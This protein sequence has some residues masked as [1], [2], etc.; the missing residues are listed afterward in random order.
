ML[1]T[2]AEHGL[3]PD[4]LLRWGIRQRLSQT[5]REEMSRPPAERNAFLT[6]MREGPIAIATDKANEQHYELPPAYFHTAL[7]PALKYSSCH[8]PEGC[9]HLNE[10]E[11]ATLELTV[12]RAGIRD[13]MSILELGCGWGSLSLFMARKFPHSR[14]VA[15][16]NSNPQR[17]FIQGRAKVEGLSHLEIRTCDMNR[18]EPG[19]TFDR[20]VS[21]EMFEHMRNYELLLERVA[22]WLNPGGKVF[23]H[24]FVHRE[25]T[26]PFR[27]DDPD[28]W[29]ARHFFTGGLMPQ[30]DVFQHFPKHLKVAE[31]WK[32]NG[33]HYAKTLDAWLARHDAAKDQIMPLF[34]TVY[35]SDAR[36]WFHRWRLFYLACSELFGY[37][38]GTEWF[39]GHYLLEKA[40]R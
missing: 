24:I 23:V 14:I 25:L 18:F 38:R 12:E 36:I 27:S 16:S 40:L 21:V 15:V 2:L 20:V 34:E 37:N 31:S 33:T 29:M 19:E 26:Y 10:A 11:F 9:K 5:L 8:W 17:E 35:G 39:V 28:E 4:P 30:F 13:G 3:L 6:S 7:G 22:S 1:L 32:L